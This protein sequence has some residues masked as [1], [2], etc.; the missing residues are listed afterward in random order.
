MSPHTTCP[1]C[2]H[3]LSISLHQ[4]KVE[5][6]GLQSSWHQMDLVHVLVDI[7]SP[8]WQMVDGLITRLKYFLSGTEGILSHSH[9]LCLSLSKY[10]QFRF[11]RSWSDLS[12]SRQ[13]SRILLI[14][15]V[16]KWG[17]SYVFFLDFK[18]S[19]SACSNTRVSS[20]LITCDIYDS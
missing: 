11:F 7:L 12:I 5:A 14:L 2:L 6:L 19:L 1:G 9:F 17:F 18:L 15:V 16:K 3:F 8:D 4:L 10:L 20:V 13:I